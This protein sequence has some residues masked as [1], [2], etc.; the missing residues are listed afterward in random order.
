MSLVWPW[1]LCSYV[2]LRLLGEGP[3]VPAV[4]QARNWVSQQQQV[5]FHLSLAV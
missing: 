3:D 4:V 5:L 1:H 2:S